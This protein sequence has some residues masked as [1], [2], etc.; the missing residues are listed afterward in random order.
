METFQ[1]LIRMRPGIDRNVAEDRISGYLAALAKNGQ[2]TGD[3]PI[4]RV[5]GGY[6]VFANAPRAD[7]FEPRW[8][9]RWVRRGPASRST[10][11]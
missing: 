6:K 9:N 10:T 5:R 11:T 2:I 7:A 4:A 8:N 1:I 3:T